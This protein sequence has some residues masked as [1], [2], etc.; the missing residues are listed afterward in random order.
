MYHNDSQT[1]RFDSHMGQPDSKRGQPD[2]EMGQAPGSTLSQLWPGNTVSGCMILGLLLHGNYS[3]QLLTASSAMVKTMT[4]EVIPG[5][6]SFPEAKP[7]DH[8]GSHSF[9]HCT[10]TVFWNVWGV[11]K[12]ILTAFTRAMVRT[13]TP[14]V[15]PVAFY[16]PEAKIERS[17]DHLGSHSFNHSTRSSQ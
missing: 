5:A 8:R 6:F 13:M 9:N 2:R 1:G 14:S 15:I 10:S 16:F 4:P 7:R 17:G 12:Q 11:I 3:I